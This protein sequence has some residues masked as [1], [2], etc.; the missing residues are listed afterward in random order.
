MGVIFRSNILEHCNNQHCKTMQIMVN[1]QYLNKPWQKFKSVKKKI[2]LPA[3]E[4]DKSRKLFFK[5]IPG[6]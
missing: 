6:S 1:V 4:C 2:H 5:N 3:K